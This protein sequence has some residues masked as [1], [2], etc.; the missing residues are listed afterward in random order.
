MTFQLTD[1]DIAAAPGEPGTL[2]QLAGIRFTVPCAATGGAVGSSCSVNTTADALTP[3]IV[4]E[5]E[6]AIWQLG[7]VIV[8]DGG[9]DGLVSTPDDNTIFLRQGVF[10]P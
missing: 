6:R 1:G 9:E 2:Q 5:G 3:G 8:L 7:R 4:K 10:V